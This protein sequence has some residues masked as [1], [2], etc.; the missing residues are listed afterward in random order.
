MKTLACMVY[1][2]VLVLN[3][4]LKYPL[5]ASVESN[6]GL[7]WSSTEKNIFT[8]LKTSTLFYALKAGIYNDK[9]PWDVTRTKISSLGG[10]FPNP[11]PGM[12]LNIR[13]CF[14]CFMHLI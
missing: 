1:V 8:P 2:H 4:G 14:L 6:V 7:V 12:S 10:W 11:I 5:Q 3:G 13:S 9:H